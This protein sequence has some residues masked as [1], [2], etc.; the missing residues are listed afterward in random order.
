MSNPD[1]DAA[2]AAQ[3]WCGL[4]PSLASGEPNLRAD[5]AALAELRRA[6][7]PAAMQIPATLDLF[8]RLGRRRPEAL[9]DIALCA[10]VLAS[11]REDDPGLRAAR[12]LGAPPGEPEERAAM[13]PLRFRRLMEAATPE[14]R[15]VAFRRAVAL[16]RGRINVRDLAA[17]CLDWSDNRRRR[18]IFEYYAAGYA[19]PSPAPALAETPEETPA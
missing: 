12:S 5:R 19:A 13:S 15:L 7:L 8:R 10:A 6:D 2:I 14:E 11:V 9:P 17:A 16:A 1:T 4:Q 3:W 18:W